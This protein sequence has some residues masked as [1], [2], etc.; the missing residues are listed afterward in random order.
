MTLQKMH[1]SLYSF[2]RPQMHTLCEHERN[3]IQLKRNENFIARLIII[4]NYF[5]STLWVHHLRER[6]E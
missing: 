3:S 1:D 4:T 2:E 6:L 5:S